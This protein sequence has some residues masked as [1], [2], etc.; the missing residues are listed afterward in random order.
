MVGL[1][2]DIRQFK[3]EEQ[4]YALQNNLTMLIVDRSVCLTVEL[5]EDTQEISEEAIGPA[6]FSNSE[7]T[8][9]AYT[10]I[11]ENLLWMHTEWDSI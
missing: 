2:I 7:S 1:G 6:T 5:E 3:K 9:F 11:L 10:S 8:V 4:I